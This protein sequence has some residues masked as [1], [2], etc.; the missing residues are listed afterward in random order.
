MKTY[1]ISDLHGNLKKLDAFT[2]TLNEDDRVYVLGDVVDKGQYP[3]P[4]LILMIKDPRF[5]MIMGNHEYM[6][7]KYLSSKEG[8]FE[9]EEAYNT[10]VIWNSGNNTLEQFEM[11]SKESQDIILNYLK[12]LPLNIPDVEV[13]GKHFYLVH[14]APGIDLD[15]TMGDLNYDELEIGKYVWERTMPGDK[16]NSY[17]RTLVT[18][19]T[20]VQAYMNNAEEL[21]KPMTDSENLDSANFIDIDGGLACDFENS[22]LIALCLDDMTYKLY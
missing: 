12:Y 17:G 9:R 6:M 15:V 1:C 7:Y 4:A 22:R 18:G 20:P 19:H 2:K 3:I 14:G 16:V 21:P 8:T 13:N 5:K 11:L 10:W